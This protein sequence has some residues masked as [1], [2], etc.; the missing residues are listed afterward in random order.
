MKEQH[1]AHIFYPQF[2]RNIHDDISSSFVFCSDDC[3]KQYLGE[4]Y[5]G[6]N[7]G[8]SL[9]QSTTCKNCGAFIEGAEEIA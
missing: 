4:G 6:E 3:H 7:G 9:Y 2:G 8:H 1:T 5:Q